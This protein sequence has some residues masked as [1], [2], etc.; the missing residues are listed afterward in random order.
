[1]AKKKD[2][3]KIVVRPIGGLGGLDG[4]HVALIVLV[5]ILIGLLLAVSYSHPQIITNSSSSCTYGSLNGS[6]TNPIHNF[7]S[8]KVRVGQ[9]LASYAS[10]NGSLSILP[11]FSSMQNMTADYIPASKEWLATVPV[12]NPLTGNSFSASFLLQDS[13]LSLINPYLQTSTT[14]K[15]FSDYVVSQGVVRLSGKVSCLQQSPIQQYWFID[16]YAPGSIQSLANFTSLQQKYSSKVNQS[17]KIVFG[18][19]S[20]GIASQIDNVNNTQALGKY[21]FCASSQ[22]NFTR[23]TSNLE[24]IYANSYVSPALL[25]QAANQSRL[26]I[27][28]LNT[29]LANATTDLNAQVL[30]AQYYNITATPSVI[31]D[32]IYQSIPQT[33]G[34]ADCY[35]N[36]TIC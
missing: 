17:I 33:A 34:K 35:A 1:M 21:I 31:T 27:P 19:A 10:V 16:P 9:I 20:L 4:I 2:E 8:V 5:A 14:S 18:S 13:N 3:T 12:M 25:S 28:E 6:C 24:S 7:S 29:C 11:Y 23:F 30:L 22:S 26:N 15:I 32:C 36:S